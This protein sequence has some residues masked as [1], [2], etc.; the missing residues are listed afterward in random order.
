MGAPSSRVLPL[1][2]RTYLGLLLKQALETG[3]EPGLG[4]EPT[5]IEVGHDAGAHAGAD[6]IAFSERTPAFIFAHVV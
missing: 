5:G 2:F 6:D 4:L 3:P 1:W